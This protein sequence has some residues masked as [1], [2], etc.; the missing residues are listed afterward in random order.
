MMALIDF[1][2]LLRFLLFQCILAPSPYS[3]SGASPYGRVVDPKRRTANCNLTHSSKES[4][5]ATQHS[6]AS[7]QIVILSA[8]STRT[9]ATIAKTFVRAKPIGSPLLVSEPPVIR[10]FKFALVL[11]S[12]GILGT[13]STSTA[14]DDPKD[15]LKRLQAENVATAK[16]KRDRPYHFGSQGNGGPF[17]NHTSH[18]NRLIPFYTFGSKIDL[19]LITGANNVY[20][21]KEKLKELYGYLPDN[22]LNPEAEYVDQSDLAKVLEN[23]KDKGAKHIFIVWFDGMDWPTTQAAAVAKTG[24]IYT[25]GRGHGLIFQDYKGAGPSGFGY[26]VT[27]PTHEEN[28]PDVD[29]QTVK[30]PKGSLKGGYDPRFGG[31]NPWTDG[32]LSAKA[33]GYLKGQSGHPQDKAGVIEAGGVLHAYTDS[34]PSA[35]EFVSGK[36]SYNNSINA[37]E[38]DSFAK[39]FF[40]RAQEEGYKLGTVTS[41]PFP[42][43][44][45]AA[46]YARNVHRDDYLDLSREMLGGLESIVVELGKGPRRPGLD[47]VIGTGYGVEAK[48]LPKQGKNAVPGNVFITDQDK[49]KIDVKNDGK[50]VVVETQKGVNGGK[51][52]LDAADTAAATG[53]RLFGLFGS[54]KIDHLPYRTTNGKFDPAPDLNGKSEVYTADD[55]NEQP[56]LVDMTKAALKVLKGKSFVLFIEAGDVDFALHSNNL[57]N[58]IGA[59]HSGEDAIK[60]VIEWVEA[61]SNWNDSAMIVAADHGHHLN[62][63][64]L[65]A[66]AGKD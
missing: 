52:L 14:A 32:P 35:A 39:T 22:T 6:R 58:A 61:H 37:L 17:S 16:D 11:F 64:D 34:A 42:H 49:A 44:S 43:A 20:R 62:I 47:V 33:P 53:V 66:I 2:R 31:P 60:A 13:V 23:A 46:M 29:T 36:K 54:K 18:S 10:S 19:G 30:I 56:T 63:N 21:D 51:A 38:D 65:K 41:V 55:L 15:H 59:V 8:K 5:R 27:S 48:A 57:D 12:T 3:G 25:E 7:L 28:I 24:E 1:L 40:H 9:N 4:D 45:P 26:Y 50:Y